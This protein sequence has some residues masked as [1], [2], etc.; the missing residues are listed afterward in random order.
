MQTKQEVNIGLLGLG[1]VGSGVAH[2]LLEKKDSLAEQ[3]GGP[4]T[5]RKVLEK[6]SVEFEPRLLTRNAE[7]ILTDPK[8]DIVIE[9]IGGEHPA[10]EYIRQA[11]TNGKHVVTANKEVIAK[12]GHELFSLAKEVNVE[13]RY[14]ASVGSGIPLISSFQ[15]GLAAND[16]SAIYAILNGTTNYILTRMAQERLEFPVALKQAQELGYA[17]SDP[18]NDIEGRDTAYKLVI[19]AN[20]AFHAKLDPQEIYCEG[21]PHLAV[22]DFLY[23]EE[24]GYV[25]KLLAIAKRY[26]NT[27]EARVHPVFLPKDSQLAKVDGV[28]NAIQ[29]EGDLAGKLLFYGEGAGGM[30][31]SSAIV[32]DV[33][34]IARNKRLG[35]TATPETGINQELIIK[36][37][38]DVETRYYFRLDVADRPGVLAQISKVLGDNSISISS[39]IQKES[40]RAAQTAEIVII[41]YPARENAT[42]KAIEQLKLLTVVNEVSSF[43][44]IEE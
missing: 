37:M 10:T 7:E 14:E 4:V 22:Q 38:T 24:F 43:I 5:L 44:R 33:L 11:L 28:Y 17:E 1:V 40:N 39:V 8:I 16:I 2:V 42:Q 25:I 31:A 34:T 6:R 23:A 27:I 41:T 36:P 19:L 18:S 12:H 32:A 26:G 29:A 21:I 9:V 15:Q 30:R 3:S 20:L 35:I 13:L